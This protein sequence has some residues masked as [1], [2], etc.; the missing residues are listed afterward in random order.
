MAISETDFIRRDVG[1]A[2]IGLLVTQVGAVLFL[3][4]PWASIPTYAGASF[5]LVSLAHLGWKLAFG[6]DWRSSS[7]ISVMLAGIPIALLGMPL[8]ALLLVAKLD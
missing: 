1:L 4:T 8:V 5:A 6:G 7:T 2:V 3:L